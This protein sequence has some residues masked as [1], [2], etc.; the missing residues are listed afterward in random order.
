MKAA[1]PSFALG[2]TVY[3]RIKPDDPG[4]VTA[5]VYRPSGFSYFVTWAADKAERAH[6]EIELT[7]DKSFG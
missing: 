5:L 3:L 4:M 1:L 2:D 7:A 6:Y